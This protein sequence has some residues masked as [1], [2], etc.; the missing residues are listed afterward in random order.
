MSAIVLWLIVSVA[1]GIGNLQYGA[2][3]YLSGVGVGLVIALVF[4]FLLGSLYGRFS[5]PKETYELK[6]DMGAVKPT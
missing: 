5:R 1:G 4:G 6:E 2:G 3:T